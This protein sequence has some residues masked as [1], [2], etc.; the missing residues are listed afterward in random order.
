MILL[1]LHPCA[2]FLRRIGAARIWRCSHVVDCARG[3]GPIRGHARVL[4]SNWLLLQTVIIVDI[5][6]LI[7]AGHLAS[8]RGNCA[9]ARILTGES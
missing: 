6:E 8:A 1:I 3:I 4:D 2:V 7:W 5:I 9:R